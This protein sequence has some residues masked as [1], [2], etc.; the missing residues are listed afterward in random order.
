MKRLF[1]VI[2][3][4]SVLSCNKADQ[5]ELEQLRSKS[6]QLQQKTV[7]LSEASE[8]V[9]PRES[10][11]YFISFDSARYGIDAGGSVT[12]N[13]SVQEASE[14]QL[15]VPQ[16]WTAELKPSSATDG[17]I[18]VTA[19]DP[20]SPADIVLEANAE[21]GRKS[22]TL[23][24]LMV[25]RPYTDRTRTDLGRLAY[26]GFD[27]SMITDY[28][29]GKLVDAGMNM[30]TVETYDDWPQ[31]LD[32]AAKYGIKVILFVNG[33][34]GR[35]YRDPSSK[36]LDN[37][38]NASKEHP[39]L[40]GYQ[41]W[42]E[43]SLSDTTAMNIAKKRIEQL[44]PGKPV[45]I[46]LHPSSAGM[47]S[48]GCATY[49]EYVERYAASCNPEFISFDQYPVYQEGITP[50]WHRSLKVVSDV[51]RRRGVPFWG[52]LASCWIDLEENTVKRARPTLENI[53]LQ[54]NTVV[55]FGAQVLQYFVWRVYGGTSYAPLMRGGIYTQAYD[56][57]SSYSTELQA[58]SWI[59]AG[60][61]VEKLR[62]S[63]LG[64]SCLE[65]LTQ[66]DLPQ[67][68]E[69]LFCG[70]DVTYSFVTNAGNEYL[71]IVNNSWQDKQTVEIEFSEMVYIIDRGGE[72]TEQPCGAASLTIDEGDMLVI[73]TK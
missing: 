9:S 3:L 19:P 21:D 58:R 60:G 24:P 55:A 30:L 66:D 50:T 67:Q 12:I 34:A 73:K 70:G 40:Y 20:A 27:T 4:A 35:Y 5:L 45:Y 69:Q 28:H 17:T 8:V 53:R 46:N 15:T 65:P 64:S 14:L 32:L 42:D 25:R 33:E 31:Q 2:L 52:F 23:L 22:V 49:E 39:A 62:C 26:L 59:F 37:I 43:P 18:I 48:L 51:A 10:G 57:C 13:Y 72:F 38:V 54:G 7:E 11:P 1:T 6:D 56:D 41:I 68:I 63:P 61:R 47:M 29:F 36:A 16:G 44:A 71:A